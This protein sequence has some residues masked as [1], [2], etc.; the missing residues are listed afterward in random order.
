MKLKR[1]Y[2]FGHIVFMNIEGAC[3]VNSKMIR[4]ACRIQST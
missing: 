2:G 4:E 3:Q 1:T